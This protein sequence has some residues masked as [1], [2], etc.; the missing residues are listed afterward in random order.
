MTAAFLRTALG[1]LV[2][3]VFIDAPEH[4]AFGRLQGGAIEDFDE[5]G[6]QVLLK[7]EIVLGQ[8]AFQQL[9]TLL[10]G[11]RRFDGNHRVADGLAHVGASRERGQMV[12]ACGFRQVNGSFALKAQL[13]A[14]F[15]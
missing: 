4:I 9:V 10:V 2:Q 14:V 8:R 6:Q 15:P 12:I 1:E 7:A 11:H 3:K 13:D 5:F